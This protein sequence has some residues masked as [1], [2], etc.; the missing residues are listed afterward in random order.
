[1]KDKWYFAT[2]VSTFLVITFVTW[3]AVLNILLLRNFWTQDASAINESLA[4]T[5][6]SHL[7]FHNFTGY[8]PFFQVHPAYFFFIIIPFYSIYP[9]PFAAYLIQTILIYGASI[10]LYFIAKKFFGE[11]LYAFIFSVSYLFYPGVFQGSGL[12]IVDM[13]IGPAIFTIYFFYA[14]R[15]IPF[16]ISFLVMAT[17]IEFAPFVGIFIAIYAVLDEKIPSKICNFKKGKLAKRELV[18]SLTNIFVLSSLIISVALIFIDSWSATYFS[19]GVHSIFNDIYNTN[20]FS[21]QS[22]ISGIQ[23]HPLTK[24]LNMLFLNGP[25]MFL[26]F[27]DPISLLQVP[28]FLVT[29]VASSAMYFN[30]GNY[31]TAFISAFV[32][33]TSI[34]GIKK[35]LEVT[36]H[37]Q[38]KKIIKRITAL[39]LVLNLLTFAGVGGFQYYASTY[40]SSIPTQ[41]QGVYFLSQQLK[42]GQPVNS[43]PYSLP[44]NE[45]Y[46]WNT[47]YYGSRN[48][49]YLIFNNS[50]PT[51]LGGVPINLSKY[52]FYAANGQF[53]MYK[54]NYNSSPIYNYYYYES[55]ESLVR[56]TNFSFFSPP[57]NYTLSLN[58][59]KI[60]YS[61]PITTG[62]DSGKYFSLDKG[63]AIGIPFEV[64]YPSIL[65]EIALTGQYGGVTY[66]Y[67]MITSSIS[68]TSFS[69]L[70]SANIGSLDFH[71]D[72]IILGANKTYYFWLFPIVSEVANSGNIG[73]PISSSN[74]T[75]YVGTVGNSGIL[76]VSP[77]NFTV[78]I[79]I[80][81]QSKSPR[82]IPIG[83]SVNGVETNETLSPQ[84]YVNLP[85]NVPQQNMIQVSLSINFTNY[86]SYHGSNITLS[87]HAKDNV[88]TNFY[89]D[90]TLIF[91]LLPMGIGIALIL[92]LFRYNFKSSRMKVH[93]ISR[94]VSALSFTGFWIFFAVGWVG[95]V[96]FLYNETIFKIVGS[97]LGI[98]LLLTMITYDWK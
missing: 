40:T 8:N 73:L 65:K 86:V 69:S 32:P 41:D 12:E 58:F 47:T 92:L 67:S 22:L 39:I 33:I 16:I 59:S 46:D 45:L 44:V 15:K 50:Y 57:G 90:H 96:P 55:Q 9:V 52:G 14:R 98:S 95:I 91:L 87:F 81:L 28:W 43:N 25:Y 42:E 36:D 94:N 62:V 76:D 71:F 1:M 30:V 29:L 4:S 21:F 31:Y 10:P 17:T 97:V 13:F 70:S 5:I 7:F 27:L 74:G 77:S 20:F 6:L 60:S 3:L 80:L 26:S 85:V 37:Q 89:L 75:S 34:Y 38:R 93:R 64:K 79:T 51:N 2:V 56:T 19:G 84:G 48:Y 78:P 24:T 23:Y 66:F 49:D 63:S 54:R 88:P 72:N 18:K 35:I 11:G 68:N 83:V 82:Q 61:Y 53:V